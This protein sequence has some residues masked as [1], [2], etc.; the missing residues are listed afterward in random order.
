MLRSEPGGVGCQL[1]IL[2][3]INVSECLLVVS[4][5]L[6]VDIGA[7]KDGAALAHVDDGSP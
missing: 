1:I 7:A 2:Q 6:A 4:G 3:S 5:L